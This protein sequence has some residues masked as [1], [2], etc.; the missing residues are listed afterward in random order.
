MTCPSQSYLAL[1][2]YATQRYFRRSQILFERGDDGHNVFLVV[3]G[4]VEIFVDDWGRALIARK[5]P[6]EVFGELALLGDGTRVASAITV[7]DSCLGVVSRP[8]FGRC[9]EAH[10]ELRQALLRSQINLIGQLTMRVSTAQLDA[11]SRLRFSLLELA[12]VGDDGLEIPGPLTQ[13]DLAAHAGCTRETAAKIMT[14][15][16]RGGWLRC[17]PDR[18]VILKPLPES[19]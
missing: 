15:L 18:L 12:R 13:R 6:G 1:L 4:Q 10:P 14:A 3:N 16:K 19:F 5:Q 8:D 11:Y 2:P 17:E 7:E 9:L